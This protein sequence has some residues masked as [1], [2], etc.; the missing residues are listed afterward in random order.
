M[1]NE[2]KI[3]HWVSLSDEDLKTATVLLNGKCYLYAGFLCHLT[4]E[5]IFKACYAKIKGDTPP[6]TH[7]LLYLAEKS[8]F[9][10]LLTDEQQDFIAEVNPLN[11]EA[12][13]PEY[14]S[15]IAKTFTST[16]CVALLEQTK[17]LQQWTK[18]KILLIK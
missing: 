6:F 10:N 2:E 3:R 11:I 17:A 5:K 18:E 4:L 12:R 14:K 1:T 15:S 7:D 8:G 13:Y 16:K 9:D